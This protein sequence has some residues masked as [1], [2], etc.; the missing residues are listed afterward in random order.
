[1]Q[2]ALR[3]GQL[4]ATAGSYQQCLCGGRTRGNRQHAKKSVGKK[5]T[6]RKSGRQVRSML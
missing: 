2:Q 6:G 1:M 4:P 3:D 5:G